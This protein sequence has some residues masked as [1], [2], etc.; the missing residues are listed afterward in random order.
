MGKAEMGKIAN[1]IDRVLAAPADAGV[2]ETVRGE[3]R[4]FASAFPIAESYV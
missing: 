4:D 2:A 3:V 1:W